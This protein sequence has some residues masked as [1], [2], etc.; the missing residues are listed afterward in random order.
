MN[1]DEI[2]RLVAERPI[3][4]TGYDRSTRQKWKKSSLK[5]AFNPFFKGAV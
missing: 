5:Q 2:A 3:R 1:N 4:G